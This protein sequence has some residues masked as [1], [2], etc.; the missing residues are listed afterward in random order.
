[1][2][3][4]E[5]NSL[6]FFFSLLA[7]L[8]LHSAVISVAISGLNGSAAG[9]RR[10]TLNSFRVFI[11]KGKQGKNPQASYSVDK[12][13]N[14]SAGSKNSHIP[15]KTVARTASGNKPVKTPKGYITAKKVP[16]SSKITGSRTGKGDTNE[17]VV[18]YEQS[19]IARIYSA[20]HYPLLSIKKREE[21]EALL[22]LVLDRNGQ[23][24]TYNI[25]RS[26]GFHRLDKEI[27]AMVSRAAPFPA[28][29]ANTTVDRIE[30]LIPVQFK[31]NK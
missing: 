15:T 4:M 14:S 30:F 26:S 16:G 21:G 22:Y 18:S 12:V 5:L 7:S 3:V 24:L 19:I 23:V 1:M 31:L 11:V 28:L 27:L 17:G 10:Q 8:L 13:S 29:P 2:P 9:I 20:K 6:N 25:K